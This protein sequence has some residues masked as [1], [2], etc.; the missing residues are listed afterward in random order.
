MPKTADLN[1]LRFTKI[2]GGNFYEKQ[3]QKILYPDQREAHRGQRGSLQGNI[4]VLFG[5]PATTLNRT[6][7]AAAPRLNFGS[8]MAI[9]SAAATILPEEQY[10]LK[11]L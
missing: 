10:R 7:S 6:A 2:N 4:T 3:R 5:T 8:A 11:R 9:A 1:F